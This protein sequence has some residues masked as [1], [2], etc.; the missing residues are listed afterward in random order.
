MTGNITGDSP[1]LKTPGKLAVKPENFVISVKL[2]GGKLQFYWQALYGLFDMT[3][4]K[5]T[6]LQKLTD[7]YRIFT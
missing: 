6:I 4:A 5:E 7:V 2:A 3:A 1:D